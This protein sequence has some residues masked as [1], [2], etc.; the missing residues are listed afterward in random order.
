MIGSA[1]QVSTWIL[2]EYGALWGE[3]ALAQSDLP[4]ALKEK[5]N[6][7]T[8]TLPDSKFLFIK[9]NKTP[10]PQ[11]LSL[12]I[13]KSTATTVEM[14][15]REFSSYEELT[16]LDFANPRTEEGFLPNDQKLILVCTNG[17]RDVCCAKFGLPVFNAASEIPAVEAWECTHIGQHRF[18]ANLIALP[19]GIYYGRVTPQDVPNIAENHVRGH[20]NLEKLRG[21]ACFPPHE[22][23][24]E[25]LLRIKLN[26]PA[27]QDFEM[28]DSQVLSDNQ[29]NV[30]IS[31]RGNIHKLT[32]ANKPTGKQIPAACTG[33][34]MVDAAEFIIQSH[35]TDPA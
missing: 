4:P 12:Y 24:A 25:A 26:D 15:K 7:F 9:S 21:R 18:A 16:G 33:E 35:E 30:N 8:Q 19:Q 5:L 11:S 2:L 20:L 23:A 22:Q 32:I 3:K 1:P 10:K 27:L 31:F 29:W 28:I 17:K 34:K 14:F 6:L 13:V